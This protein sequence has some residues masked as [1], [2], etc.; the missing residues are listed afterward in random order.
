MRA[1]HSISRLSFVVRVRDH[2]SLEPVDEA[3]SM[4]LDSRHSPVP[5]ANGSLR[6]ADGT[7]RF[8]DL[9][10]GS[11]LLAPHSP[12]G[13]WVRWDASPIEVSVP[14]A[15]PRSPLVVD[16]WP[17]AL[18]TA[19]PGVCAVRG[20]LVGPTISGL[21]V[22]IDGEGALPSGRWTLADEHGEFLFTLPGGPWP[23]TAR[24]TLALRANVPGRAIDHVEVHPDVV[25]A[26]PSFE[27]RAFGESR[28]RFYLS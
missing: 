11:Y 28:A 10:P 2:F 12:S 20:K 8:A 27:I 3:L 25:F 21:R 23:L 1:E 9:P 19:R 24:G 4:E 16:M 18:A 7:Y 14:T 5:A 26:S 22:E 17:S 15:D 6:H 13:R